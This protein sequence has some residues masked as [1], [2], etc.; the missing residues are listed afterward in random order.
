MLDN[1]IGDLILDICVMKTK[2]TVN[3]TWP[4]IYVMHTYTL[5]IPYSSVL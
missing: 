5:G 2:A 4:D 3:L 1:D